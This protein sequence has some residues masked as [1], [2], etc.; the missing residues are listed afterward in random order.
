M[1]D[2]LR[3]E[4]RVLQ[5]CAM[6]SATCAVVDV[7]IC[8]ATRTYGTCSSVEA[9]SIL[10]RVYADPA[11]LA[12]PAHLAITSRTFAVIICDADEPCSVNTTDEP[13]SSF[14]TSP[15]STTR[16][17]HVHGWKEFPVDGVQTTSPML[18]FC[19]THFP[20][21]LCRIVTPKALL[22]T[23]VPTNALPAVPLPELCPT[24]F[25]TGTEVDQSKGWGSPSSEVGAMLERP[26][27]CLG[28]TRRRRRV[29]CPAHPGSL[30]GS[31]PELLPP[32]E[33]LTI[34]AQ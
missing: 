6:I 7:S 16:P 31:R 9:S 14:T 32:C 4:P 22:P 30:G 12:C 23:G 13:E 25:A 1:R 17:F 20:S 3:G 2:S 34:L 19:P 5:S 18:E 10:T 28:W 29:A 15:W 26:P 24:I 21:R 27:S 11:S 33:T 8:Q